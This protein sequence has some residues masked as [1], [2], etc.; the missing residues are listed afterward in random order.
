MILHIKYFTVAEMSR[1][2]L[3]IQPQENLKIWKLQNS[4][5]SI[6]PFAE[7]V[8]NRVLG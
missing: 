6:P 7:S 2:P 8:Q 3:S 5:M 1:G 4:A